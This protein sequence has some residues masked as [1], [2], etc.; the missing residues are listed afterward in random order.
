MPT[1]GLMNRRKDDLLTSFV[2]ASKAAGQ[3]SKYARELKAAQQELDELKKENEFL[4]S[5]IASLRQ[6]NHRLLC[7]ERTDGD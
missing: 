4:R 7:Q 3:G 2:N 5:E 6:Q 1:D